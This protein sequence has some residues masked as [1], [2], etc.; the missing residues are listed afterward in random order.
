MDIIISAM[1]SPQI[2]TQEHL[3]KNK[4]QIIFDV[5]IKNVNNK[6]VGD[7]HFEKVKDH[8][9]AITPVPGGIG[10]MT[11]LSLAKNLVKATE[12]HPNNREH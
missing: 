4:N 11:I 9:Q 10:P 12:Q 7:V 5:G 8:V 6:P 3:A 1:G 2:I